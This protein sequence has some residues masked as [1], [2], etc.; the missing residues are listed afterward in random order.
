MTVDENGMPTITSDPAAVAVVRRNAMP[1]PI[2]AGDDARDAYSALLHLVGESRFALIG[3]ASHG[4][5]EFYRERAEITKRLI[6]EKNFNAV[7]IEADWPDAYRVNRFVRRSSDDAD[8]ASALSGFRRF[9][10]WMWRNT[11]VRDFVQWLRRH[12]DSQPPARKVGFYG[13]DLYSLLASIEAVLRYLDAVDPAAAQRARRRY[14]CF[15]HFRDDPQAYGY[16]AALGLSATCEDAVV[17]QLVET[18]ERAGEHMRRDGGVSADEYFYAEQNA[19]LVRNAEEY[20]R[21]MFRGRASSWNLRDRHMMDTL[22]ALDQYLGREGAPP[23]IAVWAHNS[24]LGD[25]SATEMRELGEWNVGQ[26]AR[27]H[28]GDQAVLNG[29]STHRGS[30]TAASDWGAPARRE[31]VRPGL[32]GSHEHLFHE[33]GLDRFQLLLRGNRAL[34]EALEQPRLQRAIGVVYL[35]GTERISHYFHAR[36]PGQFDAMIHI[37]ETHALEP[38]EPEAGW[39]AAEAPETYPSGV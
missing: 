36:L 23:R 18:T 12:N 7:A 21:T 27:E 28:Y 19:R 2:R 25:A 11:V 22:K 5:H 37:D 34:A 20:Y 15:D 32:P 16:A 3:E 38:L 29:F 8:A 13:I 26:L 39:I 4:T 10:A 14:A 6:V 9:P 30:V 35:P 33:T 24:H 1:F 17:Q 31:T